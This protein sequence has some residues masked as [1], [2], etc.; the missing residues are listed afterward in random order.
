[1]DN[2]LVILIS[3][4][5]KGIGKC[6]ADYY[7]NKNYSVIGCSRSVPDISAPNYKHF[8]IDISDEKSVKAMM[9]DIKKEFKKLDVLINNA[10]VKLTAFAV[11][12]SEQAVRES[13]NTNVIGAFLLCREAIKLMSRKKFGRI[14]NMTSIAVPLATHGSAIYSATK[15]ALEQYSKVLAKEV[16]QDKI[17]VNNIGLSFVKEGGMINSVEESERAKVLEL[18]ITKTWTKIGDITNTI[19]FLIS[20]QSEMITGQ[21][22]YIGGV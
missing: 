19:D 7:I 20:P 17:T 11:F 3:G 14:I 1:M 10:G 13:F 8:P 18:T 22:I 6:L 5:S 4:T 16:A 12:S 15:A 21:T 9:T 2:N